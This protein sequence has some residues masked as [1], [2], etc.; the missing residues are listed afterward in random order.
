MFPVW[1]LL[2]WTL[3]VTCRDI[4]DPKGP[5]NRRRGRC[6]QS[7]SP[8]GPE[9]PGQPPPSPAASSRVSNTSL[10]CPLVAKWSSAHSCWW[11]LRVG[12]SGGLSLDPKS[13]SSHGQ[14]HHTLTHSLYQP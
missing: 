13:R 14:T 5:H 9:A 11:L 3:S 4:P 8:W 12:Y 7:H 2:F 10:W 1:L 6:S